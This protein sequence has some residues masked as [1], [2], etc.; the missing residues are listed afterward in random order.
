MKTNVHHW[1]IGFQMSI[2]SHPQESQAVTSIVIISVLLCPFISKAK[3]PYRPTDEVV[4]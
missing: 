1:E 2:G 3:I 4:D